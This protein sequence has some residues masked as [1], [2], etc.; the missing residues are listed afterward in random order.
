MVVCQTA[1]S[2][3]DGLFSRATLSV[4]HRLV[5][6]QPA[7]GWRFPVKPHQWFPARAGWPIPQEMIN[8][9]FG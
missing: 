7:L 4:G 8:S 5:S 6:V 3:H 1:A 9:G 2:A